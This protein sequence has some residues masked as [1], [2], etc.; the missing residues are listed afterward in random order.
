MNACK[1]RQANQASQA[2]SPQAASL[3]YADQLQIL[4]T[5]S[6]GWISIHSLQIIVGAVF[7]SVI[8]TGVNTA[9][10]GSRTPSA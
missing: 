4:W 1:L 10:S 2:A 9:L 8:A 6:I 7:A 3:P 5:D